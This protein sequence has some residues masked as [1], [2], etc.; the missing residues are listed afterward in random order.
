MIYYTPLEF[1][2]S[3]MT[4]LANAFSIILS[5]FFADFVSPTSVKRGLPRLANY[6]YLVHLYFTRAG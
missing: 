3:A 2:L 6:V 1:S 5:G 4:P